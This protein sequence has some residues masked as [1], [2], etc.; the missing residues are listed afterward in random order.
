MGGGEARRRGVVTAAG[1]LSG[2]LVADF[3]RV[4][5]GPLATMIL[6]DLGAD[7]VKVE[8]PGSG[9][10]TRAWGPPYA[11]DGQSSYYLSVN[12]NKRSM[13]LD[14]GSPDGREVARRLAI[15]ADVLVE[16]FKQGTMERFGL[17][18]EELRVGNPGLVYARIGGFG[19]GR[20]ADLPGYDFLAQAMSGLMSIT[21][22]PDGSPQKTGVAIVDVMAGLNVSIGVLAALVE[23]SST[24]LGQRVEVDLLSTGLAG[25]VNQAS[26][27]LTAGVVPGRLGNLHPSIA[28]YEPFETATEPLVVAVGNDGQFRALCEVLEVPEVA[29]DRRWATNPARVEHRHQLHARLEEALRSRSRDEWVGALRG[30]G[31]PCG[32]I[33]TID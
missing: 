6:G 28:P 13:A 9:D 18:Y 3:S 23:R 11:P 14:L 5:A 16:N 26:S 1:P 32:P 20:G 27:Y 29:T 2:L 31:V 17:G 22:E 21:G 30:R 10:D 4:L 8:R 19:S 15:E 25:L 7:V 12:R 24:G 33:N